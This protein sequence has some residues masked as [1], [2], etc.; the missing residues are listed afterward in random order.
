MKNN[1]SF[2]FAS[3]P[4][5]SEE[6]LLAEA[7]AQ[8]L[9]PKIGRG[10]VSLKTTDKKAIE[11]ILSTRIASRVF[12]EIHCFFIKSEKQIYRNARNIAWDSYLGT[13]DTFKISTL[14]DRDS[15]VAFK[16]SIFLSQ[17]LKDS[18]VDHMRSKFGSRPSVDTKEPRVAFLQRI[19]ATRRDFK[20]QIYADLTGVS[21]DK[22]G[23]RQKGHM[24]PL[25]ENLAAALV[26]ST[27]WNKKE[28]FFDPMAGSGTILI[29]AILAKAEIP[30]SYFNLKYNTTPYSF[31]NQKWFQESDLVDWYFEKVREIIDQTNKKIEGFELGTFYANDI[32]ENNIKLIKKHLRK[33]FGRIDFVEFSN[34]DFLEMDAPEGFEGVILFNPPYGERLSTIEDLDSFYHDMGEK[35]KNFYKNSRAYIFTLHGDLRKNIRL[36]PSKKLEF[37]NGDLDCRLFRYEIS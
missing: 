22:R 5:G 3:C 14:L 16:N 31:A 9:N 17:L 36:K 29:E 4:K 2:Y 11:F 12:K 30:P 10:G 15:K 6:L 28:K 25:R 21:L 13:R 18:L 1:E 34:D 23:Y 7:Q 35:F 24:A 26:Q 20:V 32:D 19:E 8:D 33:C 37:Q 27:D